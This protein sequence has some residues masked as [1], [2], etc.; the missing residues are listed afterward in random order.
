MAGTPVLSTKN[1]NNNISP[2]PWELDPS[3]RQSEGEEGG[4][5]VNACTPWF[6]SDTS[7]AVM[8]R[9]E[10]PLAPCSTLKCTVSVTSWQVSPLESAVFRMHLHSGLSAGPPSISLAPSFPLSLS[11]C[12]SFLYTKWSWPSSQGE[13]PGSP[14]D[15]QKGRNPRKSQNKILRQFT[16]RPHNNI[17]VV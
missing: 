5:P 13:I 7:S 16:Q 6:Q 1:N 4:C 2:Q 12:L 8:K 10:L 9:L 17:T 14:E 3:Q 11:L 15:K